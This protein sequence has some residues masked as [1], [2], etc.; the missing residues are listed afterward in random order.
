MP[1]AGYDRSKCDRSRMALIILNFRKQN[2]WTLERLSKESGISISILC[3]LENST[4][5]E[6]PICYFNPLTRAGVILTHHVA[7]SHRI[8]RGRKPTFKEETVIEKPKKASEKSN[9]T[10]RG[11]IGIKIAKIDAKITFWYAKI[12]TMMD[13]L[14]TLEQKR[15]NLTDVLINN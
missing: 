8:R 1:T 15:R 13:K 14:E 9:T 12:E 10:K 6:M 2:G 11:Q 7:I 5:N 3:K 4:V